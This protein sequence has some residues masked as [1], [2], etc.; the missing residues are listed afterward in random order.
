MDIHF[1]SE[2]LGIRLKSIIYSI[3][4]VTSNISTRADGLLAHRLRTLDRSLVPP[5][6]QAEIFRH[7]CL[8]SHL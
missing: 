4:S 5:S 7:T 2:N 8:Q 6:T 3:L 1:K